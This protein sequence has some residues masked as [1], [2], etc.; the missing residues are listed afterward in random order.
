MYYVVLRGKAEGKRKTVLEELSKLGIETREG[1]IPYN[2]QEIFIKGGF[3]NHDDCLVA[4]KIGL[5]GFYI[6]S[7]PILSEE[8]K[9]YVARSLIEICRSF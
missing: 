2:T 1:F 7:G 8:E 3:T 9:K 6:P 4:N 5:N